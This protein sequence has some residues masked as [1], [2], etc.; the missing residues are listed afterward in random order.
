MHGMTDAAQGKA[1]V[2]GEN[3]ILWPSFWLDKIVYSR[4]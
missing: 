2:E 3:K 4:L 1:A